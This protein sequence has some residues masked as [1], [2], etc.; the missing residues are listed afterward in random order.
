MRDDE[1]RLTLE[2][3]RVR[4][5][6]VDRRLPATAAV[7]RRRDVRHDPHEVALPRIDAAPVAPRWN[8]VDDAGDVRVVG[9]ADRHG[10]RELRAER[11]G[12]VRAGRQLAETGAL[13]EARAERAQRREREHR[14]RSDPQGREDRVGSRLSLIEHRLRRRLDGEREGVHERADTHAGQTELDRLARRGA[15]RERVAAA[16]EGQV[17]GIRGPRPDL[18]AGDGERR[19]AEQPGARRRDD[20]RLLPL[21]PPDEAA[22]G[23]RN[24]RER[25]AAR[26]RR[27]R[28]EPE[29]DQDPARRGDAERVAVIG[30]HLP[31]IGYAHGYAWCESASRHRSRQWRCRR[32]GGRR[33]GGPCDGERLRFPSCTVP[34]SAR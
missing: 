3:V 22:R 32:R 19:L 11:R 9:P 25:S 18:H 7:G 21:Q 4:G 20:Q 12:R 14:H 1:P 23:R 30:A 33:G 6:R 29:A 17:A 31:A 13:I 26:R 16:A 8:E 15:K 28:I 24:A 5:R 2:P 27:E 34:R 10:V